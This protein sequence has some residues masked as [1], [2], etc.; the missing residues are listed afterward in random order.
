MPTFR[1]GPGLDYPSL[2]SAMT[3]EMNTPNSIYQLEVAGGSEQLSVF[4]NIGFKITSIF[5]NDP[6]NYPIVDHTANNYFNAHNTNLVEYAHFELISSNATVFHSGQDVGGDVRFTNM[7][8]SNHAG[9]FMDMNGGN[10]SHITRFENC[11]FRDF[12][13]DP[14]FTVGSLFGGGFRW[15]VVNC[16][17]QLPSPGSD[18]VVG[19]YTNAEDNQLTPSNWR[20]TN[21]LFDCLSGF[22]ARANA[23]SICTFSLMRAGQTNHGGAGM[24]FD[25]NPDFQGGAPPEDLRIN[26][27]SPAVG[28]GSNSIASPPT[29]DITGFAWSNSP[30]TD[31]GAFAPAGSS[32]VIIDHVADPEVVF[33]SDTEASIGRDITHTANPEVVFFSDTETILNRIILSDPSPTVVFDSQ[34]ITSVQ[35]TGVIDHIANPTVSFESESETEVIFVRIIEHTANPMVVFTSFANTIEGR[36]G[37][38]SRINNHKE[39]A[40]NRL[41]EQYKR[42]FVIEKYLDILVGCPI[43]DLEDAYFTLFEQLNINTVSGDQLDQ[44]GDIVGQ[45]RLGLKD[46]EYR[47]SIKGRIGVNNSKGTIDNIIQI[48]KFMS[49]ADNII[50]TE[51][52]PAEVEISTDVPISSTLLELAI[53]FIEQVIGAGI[54][55]GGVVIFD[56]SNAFAFE[57]SPD[58]PRTGGFGDL[59][60]PFAGGKLASFLI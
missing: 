10:A 44:I 2:V 43:Q 18:V 60:D 13:N 35:K 53:S 1:I 6:A 5:A 7:V 22:N 12:T 38:L 31:G 57:S 59:D 49:G 26:P 11:I 55:F 24:V 47:I 19:S 21:N 51:N 52:F 30:D 46:D 50:V 36:I 29:V 16:T 23:R 3:A 33:F 41:L 27:T 48:W 9:V 8:I 32:N 34:S 39:Q 28:I 15:D 37:G 54:G 58:D 25:N 40:R 56:P 45:P 17:F 42:K 4:V 20:W 14:F